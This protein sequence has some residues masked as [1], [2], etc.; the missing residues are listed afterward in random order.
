MRRP[1]KGGRVSIVLTFE[2]PDGG[3]ATAW[4]N[5]DL[6]EGNKSKKQCRV[7]KNCSFTKLYRLSTGKEPA[8]RN[9]GC[10]LMRHLVGIFFFIELDGSQHATGE[11]KAINVRPVE[12][13]LCDAWTETGMLKQ[14][15]HSNLGR[16]KSLTKQHENTVN[17]PY[18]NRKDTVKPPYNDRKHS[19]G[20][21]HSYIALPT[22]SS[23][24]NLSP[25]TNNQTPDVNTVVIDVINK[26][27]RSEFVYEP[28]P[29]LTERQADEISVPTPADDFISMTS[30]AQTY[31]EQH[32]NY[33]TSWQQ[34]STTERVF[35]YHQKP[36]EVDGDYLDRILNE[37]ITDL[38]GNNNKQPT[39]ASTELM[40]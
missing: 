4:F 30:E 32:D 40:R 37:S 18:K 29:T 12:P 9:E 20:K 16:R 39:E 23:T 25:V 11:L 21:P 38:T 14:K 17:N 6:V 15:P 35:H 27:G 28:T 10:T 24:N 22:I 31:Y 1:N 2:L 5:V 19:S 34:V 33:D 36:Q 3:Q 13:Y 7:N 8:R 26:Q